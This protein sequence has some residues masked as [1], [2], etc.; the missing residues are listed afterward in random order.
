ML[1][2]SPTT[3]SARLKRTA[4]NQALPVL[5]TF[6]RC[7]YAIR[8]RLALCIS[9]VECEHREVDLKNKPL[10]MLELSPKGT[11]PVLWLTGEGGRVIDESLA[12]MSWA[13]ER[14]DPLSWTPSTE[15]GKALT[16]KLI[17]INDGDFKKHLDRYKYPSRF[18]L[19]SGQAFR[20]AGLLILEELDQILSKQ[21]F[22]AGP[23]FSFLD[24]ALAPF[25]RQ[26][27]RTDAVWF[28]QQPVHHLIRWLDYFESSDVFQTVMKKQIS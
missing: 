5:Y 10:H 14:K 16:R 25:V 9:E 15:D 12:I 20:D 8:A 26:F 19:Q 18:G 27:A 22:L 13:L 28:S 21:A 7:P 6:R 1:P 11:V 17:E 24:A 2:Q 4:N 23:Y 3:D